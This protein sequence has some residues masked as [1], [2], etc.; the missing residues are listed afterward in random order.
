ML[1]QGRG[2]SLKAVSFE[3][4]LFSTSRKGSLAAD[5]TDPQDI[6]FLPQP[7]AFISDDG[8]FIKIPCTNGTIG[9]VTIGSYYD[10]AST[11]LVAEAILDNGMRIRG[12]LFS[13]GVT[14]IPIPKQEL[15]FSDK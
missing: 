2:T 14:E 12:I 1:L 3:L 4:K 13:S 9:E 5:L 11:I 7:N 10:K 8:Q 6:R 15:Q